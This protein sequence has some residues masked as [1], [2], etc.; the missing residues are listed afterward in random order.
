M[1]EYMEYKGYLG[2]V[3]YSADDHCL[4]GKLE[5]IAALISYEAESITELEKSFQE[6]V[7]HYLQM[8]E[9][10][11]ITPQKPLKG[12]FNVRISPEL[13]RKAVMAAG[14]KSLN[15]FVTEAIKHRL[16]A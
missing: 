15:S 8:C 11:K 6:S 9:N 13:H 5:F 3:E 14:S 2:T 10:E 12:T 16:E 7:E 1:S 4:Y